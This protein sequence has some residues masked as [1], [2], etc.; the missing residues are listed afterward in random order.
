MPATDL[1]AAERQ[2]EF[3]R[4]AVAELPLGFPLTISIGVAQ[5]QSGESVDQ[6]LARAD[7]ALYRAKGNGRN[8]VELAS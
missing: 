6:M 5:H 3:L 7:K 8:R 2:C 4:L 1:R